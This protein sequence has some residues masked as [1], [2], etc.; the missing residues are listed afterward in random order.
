MDEVKCHSIRASR[1]SERRGKV[2]AVCT[3]KN[4]SIL[5][6]PIDTVLLDAGLPLV[7]KQIESQTLITDLQILVDDLEYDRGV[8]TIIYLWEEH[9]EV[10]KTR[11]RI[12]RS[13]NGLLQNGGFYSDEGDSM[14]IKLDGQLVTFHQ[15]GSKVFV[16]TR[17]GVSNKLYSCLRSPVYNRFICDPKFIEL[18]SSEGFVK[19]EHADT[20][21]HLSKDVQIYFVEL[22]KIIHG[23]LNPDTF[24]YNELG[25]FNIMGHQLKEIRDV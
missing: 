1:L 5:V 2:Y 11:F 7:V 19:I 6:Y 22:N 15:E 14:P 18:S 24:E 8:D 4:N 17:K 9:S 13:R 25:Q 16:V 3:D 23:I 21:Q 10:S 20:N 12:L